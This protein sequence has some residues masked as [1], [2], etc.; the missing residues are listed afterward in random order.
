MSDKW[1]EI[2]LAERQLT[3]KEYEAEQSAAHVSELREFFEEHFRETQ[4]LVFAV[5][6]EH[7]QTKLGLQCEDSVDLFNQELYKSMDNINQVE[8]IL[9][10]EK[11][12][13]QDELNDL[14]Y[15]KRKLAS[16]GEKTDGR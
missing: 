3:D 9:K 6:E 2:K 8:E 14:Y 5:K 15:E 10:Q 12:K 11:Q 16:E 4:Q 1:D 7:A 13:I